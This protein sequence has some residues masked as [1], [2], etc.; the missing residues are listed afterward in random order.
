VAW[1]VG[2]RV[3]VRPDKALAWRAGEVKYTPASLHPSCPEGCYAVELDAP[4]SSDDWTGTTRRYGGAELVGGPANLV[5]VYEHSDKVAEGDHI[6]S[7]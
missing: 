4:V 1:I 7:E 6:R 2:D 5:F 3:E